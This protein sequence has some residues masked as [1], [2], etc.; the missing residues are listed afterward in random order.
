MQYYSNSKLENFMYWVRFNF[1]DRYNCIEIQTLS[2]DWYDSD[3]RMLHANFQLLADFI[4]IEKAHIQGSVEKLLPKNYFAR[5]WHSVF[6]RNYRSRELGL[7]YLDWELAIPEEGLNGCPGQAAA[8]KELKELYLW[9]KD[10]YSN[11]K[12]P[13]DVT[14]LGDFYDKHRGKL[15]KFKPSE[16]HP[17]Y[18]ESHSDLTEEEEREHKE[19]ADK[20]WKV[21]EAYAQEEEDMLIRLIKVRRNM[22]T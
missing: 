15:F 4:E 6:R 9:W 22:W 7:K 17:G 18:F 3:T 12:D 11:R 10:T 14:G 1:T 19:L 16:S 8:A 13:I 2:N 21:E 5:L 20:T